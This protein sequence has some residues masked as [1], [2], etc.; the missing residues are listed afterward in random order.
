L[1]RKGKL[2][3]KVEALAL[4][5]EDIFTEYNLS[6]EDV[7]QALS[8][9]TKE[10]IPLSVFSNE[11]LSALEIIVKYFKENKNKKYSEIAR[12]LNRDDRT[13]WSTYNNAKKKQTGPLSKK[14][15][16]IYIPVSIFSSRKTSVLESLVIYLKNLNY[17][18]SQIAKFLK[19]DYQTI[20]TSYR[21]GLA[22]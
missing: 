4:I 12:L 8:T 19:K 22:K 11:K 5:L 17:T 9:R 6:P 16:Q 18:F 10:T 20:Y 21:R 1:G 3:Q 2:Q 14:K 13:I 15:S 7:L